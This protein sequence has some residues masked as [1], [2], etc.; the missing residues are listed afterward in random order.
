MGIWESKHLLSTTG[1]YRCDQTIPNRAR[2]PFLGRPH[3]GSA[4]SRPDSS[5][6]GSNTMSGTPAI[7]IVG[8]VVSCQ[9]ECVRREGE[10]HILNATRP[11]SVKLLQT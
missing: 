6:S 10:S 4:L 11:P 5:N 9:S 3:R 2:R 8:T 7:R 1:V